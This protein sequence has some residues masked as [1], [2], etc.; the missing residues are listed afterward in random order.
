MNWCAV[1]T[2]VASFVCV[3]INRVISEKN[4]MPTTDICKLIRIRR[5]WSTRTKRRTRSRRE[6]INVKPGGRENARSKM[7]YFEEVR[8]IQIDLLSRDISSGPKRSLFSHLLIVFW[9]QLKRRNF[10][11]W[12]WVEPIDSVF[13]LRLCWFDNFKMKIL[14][15]C[16]V[17][18]RPIV[19][20]I[21][22]ANAPCACACALF[23]CLPNKNKWLPDLSIMMNS[24]AFLYVFPVMPFR[25]DWSTFCPEDAWKSVSRSRTIRA[26]FCR[27]SPVWACWRNSQTHFQKV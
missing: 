18:V 9:V 15:V 27:Y 11:G 22:W 23:Y 8:D 26:S 3:H 5:R 2:S 10:C 24:C 1:C 19:Y 13:A 6:R 25:L 16:N 7:I 20:V 21:R 12:T 4:F 14:F 17:R